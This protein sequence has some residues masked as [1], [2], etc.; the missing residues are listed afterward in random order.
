LDSKLGSSRH[1][2]TPATP[3]VEASAD[4]AAEYD[5]N[6]SEIL[7]DHRIMAQLRDLFADDLRFY[8]RYA[9]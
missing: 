7:N 3:R 2:P 9:R 6:R 5:T 4:L 8:E 1:Q